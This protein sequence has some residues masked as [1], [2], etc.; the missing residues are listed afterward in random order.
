MHD[1]Y[2]LSRRVRRHNSIEELIRNGANFKFATSDCLL[3]ECVLL[4][5]QLSRNEWP[6]RSVEEDLAHRI[7]HRDH[8]GGVV[9]IEDCGLP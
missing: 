4:V 9:E 5:E 7:Q 8:C 6:K 2:V 1:Q 3:G